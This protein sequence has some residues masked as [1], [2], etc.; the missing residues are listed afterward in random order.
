MI[1]NK[2]KEILNQPI[3]VPQPAHKVETTLYGRYND[4]KPLN[5][6]A[7]MIFLWSNSILKEPIFWKMV[8]SFAG[9]FFIDIVYN[10][11]QKRMFSS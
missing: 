7:M 9:L 10:T 8:T 2:L 4:V 11:R 1:C 6:P 5:V 3:S